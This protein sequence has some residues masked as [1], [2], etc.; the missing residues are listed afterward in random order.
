MASIS[1]YETKKGTRWM[2]KIE[3]GIDPMT[4]RRKSTTKRGFL[5]QRD[6]KREVAKMH[7]DIENGKYLK[8][9]KI[10]FSDFLDI[11]F[12]HYKTGNLKTSTINN[13]KTTALPHLRKYLGQKSIN[14]ITKQDYEFMLSEL[15]RKGYSFHSIDTTNTVGKMVFRYAQEKQIIYHNYVQTIKTPS[16][17]KSHTPIEINKIEEKYLDRQEL[18]HLLD[19]VKT[20]GTLL[21]YATIMTLSYTG[22]RI[23]ELLALQWTDINFETHTL[24]VWKTL[25]RESNTITHY[26]LTTPKTIKSTREVAIDD[27]VL[28]T[29]SELLEIQ[30]FIKKQCLHY[31]DKNF[32]FAK[33]SGDY[34][35]YPEMRH[36]LGY[37]LRSFLQKA[38][39]SKNITLHRLRHTHISLLAQAGVDLTTIQERVGHES[40]ETTTK[41]YLHVTKELK[42][43]SALKFSALMN[44]K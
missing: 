13:R 25:F 12:D 15:T 33:L 7:T 43:E 34:C 44:Q 26:E 11:W 22:L 19:I 40:S 5:T 38:G 21:E 29:L 23:G 4:G 2:I 39:I 1:K 14:K 8:Q 24:S 41:I 30:Q 16:K 10:M 28:N 42:Q 36:R 31:H 6:A 18:L 37:K 20:E 27:S 3:L 17:P 9:E 35:G 32:I